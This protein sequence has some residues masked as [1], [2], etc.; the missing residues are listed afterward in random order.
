[1]FSIEIVSVLFSIHSYWQGFFASTLGAFVWKVLSVV[2]REEVES[3][4]SSFILKTNF[5]QIFPYETLELLTFA[6]LGI[7]CG[8]MGALFVS[9][10]KNIVIMTQKYSRMTRFMDR[11]PY[12]YPI[13]VTT[14]IAVLSFPATTGKYYASWLSSEDALNQLFDNKTWGFRETDDRFM[15]NWQ[16]EVSDRVTNDSGTFLEDSFPFL[17]FHSFLSF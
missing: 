8:L 14:F 13:I 10:Q 2:F 12:V 17:F 4:H 6:L 3:Y 16:T 7:M 15:N 11:F 1:M 9:I 5:R